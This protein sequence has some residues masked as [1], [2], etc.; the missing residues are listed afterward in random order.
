MVN[1]YDIEN[2]FQDWAER[3]VVCEPHSSFTSVSRDQKLSNLKATSSEW[4]YRPNHSTIASTIAPFINHCWMRFLWYP[5]CRSMGYQ[6]K[7]KAD[8]MRKQ[9]KVCDLGMTALKN[10]APRSYMTWLPA[11]LSVLDMIMGVSK[12]RGRGRGQGR[13]RTLFYRQWNM[14]MQRTANENAACERRICKRF[15]QPKIESNKQWCK[16]DP[17]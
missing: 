15:D 7:P 8:G 6:P 16:A 13:D 3:M 12:T 4:S 10:H 5:E 2:S 17:A 9:H 1:D 11:N 14:M